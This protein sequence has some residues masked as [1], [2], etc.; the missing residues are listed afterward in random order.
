MKPTLV[1]QP[2]SGS[3]PRLEA[4]GKGPMAGGTDTA[5]PRQRSAT[6][7]ERATRPFVGVVIVIV[8]FVMLAGS[9]ITRGI[10]ARH[11]ARVRAVQAGVAAAPQSTLEPSSEALAEMEV[12]GAAAAQRLVRDRDEFVELITKYVESTE[13][14]GW[15]VDLNFLPSA[16]AEAGLR[17]MTPYNAV[18]QLS[19]ATA[20]DRAGLPMLLDGL[21]GIST[22]PTLVEV[23]GLTVRGDIGGVLSLRA[24]LQSLGRN[25]DEKTASE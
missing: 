22:S 24:E 23:T 5:R 6:W 16:Q 2:R 13:N 11:L 18:A 25:T 3:P 20:A 15:T 12:Q 9:L 19:P 8:S 10:A 17:E 7:I 21:D 1:I 14:H 4:P